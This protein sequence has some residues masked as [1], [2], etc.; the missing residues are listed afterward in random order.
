MAAAPRVIFKYPVPIRDEFE[1]ELPYGANICL[2]AV[3]KNDEGQDWPQLWIEHSVTGSDRRVMR[4]F[5]LFGTGDSIEDDG[6]VHIGSVIM[7]PFVRHLFEDLSACKEIGSW[8]C[9]G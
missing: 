2:F 8:G 7:E 4:R 6:L 5:H 1:L 9:A 3:K